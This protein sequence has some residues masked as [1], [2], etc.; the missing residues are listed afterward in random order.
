MTESTKPSTPRGEPYLR[1]ESLTKN[2]GLFTALE[3]VSLE[4]VEGEF[5]CCLGPSGCGKTTLLRCIAGLDIQSSGRVIQS[6]RDISALP[7][8]ERDFG[9]VFQSY[10]LFPNLTVRKNVAYG[11][12]NRKAS[13]ADINKRVNELLDLV[14]LPDQGDKYPAQLSGGQQQRIAVARAIATSPGLLLLDEP[15]SALDAKVRVHLR[16]EIKQ[17]QRRLGI[18]TLMVTHDQEEALTMADRIVV[19]DNGVIDQIGT[20]LEIYRE[21]ATSFV[22]DF[23]GTMNFFGG[24]VAGP[25]AVRV[26]E[27]ELACP[28]DGLATGSRVTIAVRPE[29]FIVQQVEPSQENAFESE[30]A[31][32]EFLGSFVRAELSSAAMGDA[33]PRADLSINVV[34][35]MDINEGDKLWL[36][37]PAERIRLYPV[38]D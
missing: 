23:I 24:H 2:F 14:G 18:T 17:L 19:M 5:V 7:P 20:P 35:A 31:S 27:L 11:L 37:V 21:P 15:L 30:I 25:G 38:D 34:R 10:A 32:M 4:I 28:A 26:G 8:S 22:A 16:H 1:V 6:G 3:D 36:R 12:E 9:I 33:R 29:D 13:S